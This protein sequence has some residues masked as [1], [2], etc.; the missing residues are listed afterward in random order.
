MYPVN[1]S[2]DGYLNVTSRGVWNGFWRW[3]FSCLHSIVQ[4]FADLNMTLWRLLDAVLRYCLNQT[5]RGSPIVSMMWRKPKG[6]K[7]NKII[8]KNCCCDAYRNLGTAAQSS[9]IDAPK[10]LPKYWPIFVYVRPRRQY[11]GGIWR[12]RLFVP[13]GQKNI[14]KTELY[15]NDDMAII[16]WF[17]WRTFPQTQIQTDRWLFRF[18][19]LLRSVD[20]KHLIRFQRQKLSF[21]ISP[22]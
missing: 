17:S 14:L 18:K 22:T 6:V 4:C 9:K 13:C 12:R 8:K 1:G 21:Q 11:A 5:V 7:W 15:E 20:G 10:R 16:L 3:I 2:V 19:Y